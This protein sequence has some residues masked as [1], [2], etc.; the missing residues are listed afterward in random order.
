VTGGES[1]AEGLK[2]GRGGGGRGERGW[3]GGGGGGENVG[4][5]GGEKMGGRDAKGGET[6]K[7]GNREVSSHDQGPTV[8]PRLVSKRYLAG[9]PELTKSGRQCLRASTFSDGKPC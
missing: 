1:R 8:P 5:R 6:E 3:G 7:E 9:P 4:G 2:G